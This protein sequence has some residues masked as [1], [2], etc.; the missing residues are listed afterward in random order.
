MRATSWKAADA[1][2]GCSIDYG[3]DSWLLDVWGEVDLA[4]VP[5]MSVFVDLVR[6][7]PQPVTVDFTQTTFIDSTGIALLVELFSLLQHDGLELTVV[8]PA[9]PAKRIIELSGISAFVQVTDTVGAHRQGA[10]CAVI[11]TDMNGA[12]TSWNRAAEQLYGRRATD[13][14]GQSILDLMVG[15]QDGDH[16]NQI[17]QSV[18]Q[19]GY[20][21]GEFDVLCA[22][23]KLISMHVIDRVLKDEQGETVGVVGFSTPARQTAE[24]PV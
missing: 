12:V 21:E 7:E 20:W 10:Q 17:M 2:F 18:L 1:D 16:A 6:L 9:G 3:G 19:T 23:R 5:R 22:D 15:P 24:T 14:I 13:V 8:A 11:T 4:V